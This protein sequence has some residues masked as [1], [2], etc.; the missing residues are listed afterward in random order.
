[1]KTP[2]TILLAGAGIQ[3]IVGGPHNPEDCRHLYHGYADFLR[4]RDKTIRNLI[5]NRTLDEEMKE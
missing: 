1:M 2:F 3:G 5:A 4:L